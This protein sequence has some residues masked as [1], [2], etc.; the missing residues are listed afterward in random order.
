MNAACGWR[1]R[2][3]VALIEPVAPREIRVRDA[4]ADTHC[5]RDAAA[6]GVTEPP[7]VCWAWTHAVL[8]P[9]VARTTGSPMVAALRT[10]SL[11][12]AR[13]ASSL[14]EVW[15]DRSAARFVLSAIVGACRR[16]S[17][18]V[19]KH[20]AT[21]GIQRLPVFR[22]S[23][24]PNRL[25][26]PTFV[27]LTAEKPYRVRPPYVAREV[28]VLKTDIARREEVALGAYEAPAPP[29][30]NSLTQQTLRDFPRRISAASLLCHWN[31]SGHFCPTASGDEK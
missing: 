10:N 30:T 2:H 29:R 3:D 31:C 6:D 18:R 20:A 11:R 13:A 19:S 17:R 24:A 8:L 9:T 12:L 23:D 16:T 22:T 4:P 25:A 21:P 14:S 28:V 27:C 7:P 5:C 26:S 1:E 15:S